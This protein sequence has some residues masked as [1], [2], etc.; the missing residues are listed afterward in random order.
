MDARELGLLY[1]SE[2]TQ[3][4]C[5]ARGFKLYFEIKAKSKICFALEQGN[6]K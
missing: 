5:Q 6:Y 1:F 3:E 4:E 2:Q